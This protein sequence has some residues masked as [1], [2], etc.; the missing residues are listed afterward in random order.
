ML[1]G[2][3]EDG[4]RVETDGIQAHMYVGMYLC[5]YVGQHVACNVQR[6]LQRQRGRPG[7]IRQ[8][9]CA[10]RNSPLGGRGFASLIG[11]SGLH[12]DGLSLQPSGTRNSSVGLGEAYQGIRLHNE[13]GQNSV[14]VDEGGGLNRIPKRASGVYRDLRNDSLGQPTSPLSK[15]RA[16][17]GR[18]LGY[19]YQ[20][21][22]ESSDVIF[23]PGRV[24]QFCKRT[25]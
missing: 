5:R 18:S 13:Q 2:R 22:A 23:G 19:T 6:Q 3:E 12:D 20:S 16:D 15:M 4:T 25:L 8:A 21:E 9:R 7:L 14:W 24:R 17:Q 1:S 10:E 11:R